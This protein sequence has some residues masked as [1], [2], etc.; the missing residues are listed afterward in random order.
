[1]AEIK[2]QNQGKAYYKGV[3]GSYPSFDAAQ[4]ALNNLPDDVKKGAGVKTWG[5]VQ[6]SVAE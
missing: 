3:Y 4:Q 2:Y 6:S 1:M 5:S